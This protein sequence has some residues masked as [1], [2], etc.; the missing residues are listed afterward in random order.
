MKNRKNSL[1]AGIMTAVLALG[2]AG[3]GNPSNPASV[4]A[5]EN[6]TGTAADAAGLTKVRVG[7]DTM[8]LAYAQVIGKQNGYYEK[9]GID[10]EITT[11]AAG[12]E[13][14]NAIVTGAADIGAAYDYALCTRLIPASNVRV[15]SNFVTNA[16][17][18]YWFETSNPEIQSAAD[19]SKGRI[20]IV[21]GTLGEYLIAKELESG[22]LTLADADISY[23]SSDGEVVA[24]LDAVD[25]GLAVTLGED[26]FF[27]VREVE[28]D[29]ERTAERLVV[30]PEESVLARLDLGHHIAS[31]DL[32]FLEVGR[33]VRKVA[34]SDIDGAV[35]SVEELEPGALLSEVVLEVIGVDDKVLVQTHLTLAL[36]ACSDCQCQTDNR[37]KDFD[38]FHLVV[39]Y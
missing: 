18:S 11:Y 31:R 6:K 27:S 32:V 13:T 16:D 30:S 22:G 21:K 17:G 24:D 1:I 14:I 33:I 19:L 28:I 39:Q 34:A 7:T 20:G 37:K 26:N 10:V 5:K 9:N 29:V 23:L 38:S 2:A 36:G 25:D 35:R 8:Q 15:L 3:C 12:I 4:Q